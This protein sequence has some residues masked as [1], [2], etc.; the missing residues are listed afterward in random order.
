[1]TRAGGSHAKLVGVLA[2][3]QMQSL[4]ECPQ[5]L[6]ISLLQ[7]GWEAGWQY[8]GFLGLAAHEALL[9]DLA[10][11]P[12]LVRASTVVLPASAGTSC[13]RAAGVGKG[14]LNCTS[15]QVQNSLAVCIVAHGTCTFS[16]GTGGL[17]DFSH[18]G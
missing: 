12:I 10:A 15:C 1:M 17:H 14:P 16:A 9:T 6:A 3:E 18:K 2:S 5:A 13:C 11:E 7:V 8:A 4:R